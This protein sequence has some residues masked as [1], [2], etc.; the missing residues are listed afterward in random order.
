MDFNFTVHSANQV[1]IK[2]AATLE[3]GQVVEALVQ[4]LVAELVS[5][6]GTMSQTYRFIPED[7]A[8]AT[9][10]FTE[11]AQVVVSVSPPAS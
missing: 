10:L 9:A 11:G 8:T 2:T 4:G 5:A 1:Q 6:D 7:F 3:G